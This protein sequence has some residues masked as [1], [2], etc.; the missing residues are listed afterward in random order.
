MERSRGPVL[1]VF[2][3]LFVVLAISNFLKPFHLD[4]NAGLVI[5]GIKTAG[6]TN[7]ILAPLFGI[8]LIVY[9]AGIW[10]MRRWALPIAYAYA[11]YVVLNMILFSVF[12]AGASSRPSIAFIVLSLVAG[13]G[14]PAATAILLS[15]R[16]A[17]LT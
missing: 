8:F 12:S 7:A 15:R 4:P 1:T 2:A 3:I 11:G 14:V 16:K 5:F 17:Q 9:A 6:M 13:I 10:R